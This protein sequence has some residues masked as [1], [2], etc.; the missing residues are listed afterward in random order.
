MTAIHTGG[1]KSVVMLADHISAQTSGSWR[2]AVSARAR[3]FMLENQRP[4]WVGVSGESL[5]HAYK[6]FMHQTF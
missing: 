2:M 5:E 4:L 1:E 6:I 3:R